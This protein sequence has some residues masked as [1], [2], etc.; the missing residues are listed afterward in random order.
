[1]HIAQAVSGNGS[2]K[3]HLLSAWW[4]LAVFAVAVALAVYQKCVR[5][6]QFAGRTISARQPWGR[7]SDGGSHAN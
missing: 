2:A 4:L 7:M 6:W 5:A 1:L 3:L